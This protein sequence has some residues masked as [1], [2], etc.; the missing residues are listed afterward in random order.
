MTRYIALAWALFFTFCS[1]VAQ[2]TGVVVDDNDGGPVP[3]AS[4]MYKGNNIAASCDGNGRFTIG[5][6]QGWRLTFSS[7]GYQSQV[8]NVNPSTP[9]NLTIRLKSESRKLQEVT[10]KSKKRTSYSRRNNPAVDLI[11]KV[12]KA[13]KNNDIR[14]HDYAR[15]ENYRKISVSGQ[16]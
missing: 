8:I 6:H 10:I 11:R 2:I 3:Y 12:I 16:S 14:Q 9:S 1:A 15:Y 7:V 5:R 13:K 4:V